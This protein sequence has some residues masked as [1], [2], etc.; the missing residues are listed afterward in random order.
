MMSDDTSK[1]AETARGWWIWLNPSLV[2]GNLRRYEAYNK[3][4]TFNADQIPFVKVVEYSALEQA[5]ARIAELEKWLDT[6]SEVNRVF[7][8]CIA[9]LKTKLAKQQAIIECY[10]KALNQIHDYPLNDKIRVSLFMA[11][12]AEEALA[13]AGGIS[14]GGTPMPCPSND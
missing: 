1:P 11:T 3:M 7:E 5:N 13:E 2:G 6:K 10:E 14:G 8:D 12:I 4:P 9:E